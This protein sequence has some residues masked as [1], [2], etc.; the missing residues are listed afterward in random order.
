MRQILLDTGAID[1]VESMIEERA[2]QAVEALDAAP[3]APEARVA[4][5]AMTAQL[6]HRDS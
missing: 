1:R 2:G 5:T 3:I 4:L 6:A